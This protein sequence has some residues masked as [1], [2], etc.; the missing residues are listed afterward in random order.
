M[1]R[2]IVREFYRFIDA[3][4]NKPLD[5]L[6]FISFNVIGFSFLA[7]ILIK[8]FSIF[9]FIRANSEISVVLVII[10][11]VLYLHIFFSRHWVCGN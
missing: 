2:L 9:G 10:E 4:K 6:E 11:I 5:L 1:K 3:A 7:V 8:R